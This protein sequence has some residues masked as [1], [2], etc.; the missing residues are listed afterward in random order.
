MVVLVWSRVSSNLCR[1]C[2][3]SVTLRTP[4]YYPGDK[5]AVLFL[6]SRFKVHLLRGDIQ[7][8]IDA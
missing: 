4:A 5:I 6:L 7:V 2:V 3:L 8:Q 1:V